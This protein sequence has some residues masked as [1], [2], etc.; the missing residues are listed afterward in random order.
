MNIKAIQ[1]VILSLVAVIALASCSSRTY[2]NISYLQDVTDEQT[3][4][5]KIT[6]G[7]LIQP[8]DKISIVVSHRDPELASM[9]NLNLATMRV[10]SESTGVRGGENMGYVVDSGGEINFPGLG[11]LYVAGMTRWELQSYIQ[12]ELAER[13]LLRD[14]VVNVEFMNLKVSVM[15]EVNSPGTYS[16]SGDKITILQALS[17][18]GDLTI[19][20][21]RN[22]VM[23]IREQG[24]K[25]TAFHVD[26]RDSE[27]FNSPAYYL[28][29]S[30]IIYV[31]P[32]KVRAGQSTLNENSVKTVGF[33]TSLSSTVLS[34]VNM[35]L[36]INNYAK[37]G[38]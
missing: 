26:L 32:N 19:Y 18:A 23:V 16:F 35:V 4:P 37:N 1:R 17:L 20:G 2:K 33:W 34:V 29:Q 13:Q 15:G 10:S 38:K 12:N 9:F 36:I 21:K 3:W 25:R 5:M 30:D 27:L 31:Y 22:N 24:K 8:Q 28:Q 11:V 14:A 7:I 6:S